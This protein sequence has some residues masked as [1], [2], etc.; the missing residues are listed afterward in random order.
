MSLSK[1]L[2]KLTPSAIEEIFTNAYND[3]FHESLHKVVSDSE[4]SIQ[5]ATKERDAMPEYR[6]AKQAVTDLSAGLREVRQV[7]KAKAALA[8][9]LLDEESLSEDDAEALET[10]RRSW[11]QAKM[12]RKNTPA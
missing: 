5:K 10:A 6:K 11:A 2:D 8:L 7:Q 9:A 1:K 12:T 4:A 3:E